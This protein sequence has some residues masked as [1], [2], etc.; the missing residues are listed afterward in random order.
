MKRFVERI[1]CDKCKGTVYGL[2][3]D[4]SKQGQNGEQDYVHKHTM[5]AFCDY[6]PVTKEIEEAKE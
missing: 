5:S 3:K 2:W 4:P 1:I 6:N